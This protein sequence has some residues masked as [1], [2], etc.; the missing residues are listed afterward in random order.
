MVPAPGV[1][2]AVPAGQ[3][4]VGQWGK[5]T[6]HV[7]TKA[8]YSLTLLPFGRMNAFVVINAENPGLDVFTC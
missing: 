2:V 8:T 7:K 5:F 6:A 1:P 4:A 3:K